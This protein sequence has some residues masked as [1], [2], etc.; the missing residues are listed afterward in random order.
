MSESGDND[1]PEQPEWM[2]PEWMRLADFLC[3]PMTGPSLLAELRAEFPQTSRDDVYR[4]IATAWTYQQSGWLL[5]VM[6]LD[7]IKRGVR[8]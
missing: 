4:A 7:M 5:D 2:R 8:P 6:E 1:Q 3:G